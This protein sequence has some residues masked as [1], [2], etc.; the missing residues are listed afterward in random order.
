[1]AYSGGPLFVPT[2][3]A[4]A[5]NGDLY[6]TNYPDDTF[7][8]PE[9]LSIPSNAARNVISGNAVSGVEFYD[10]S[11]ANTVVGNLIG[12]AADGV[13]PLGNGQHGVFFFGPASNV[14]LSFDNAIGTPSR[15]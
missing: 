13:T 12:T 14:P 10:G 9:V 4:V 6:I 3:L 11:N 7:N 5:P 8:H 15:A 2:E 1:M